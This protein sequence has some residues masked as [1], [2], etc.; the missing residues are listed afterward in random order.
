M[1]RAAAAMTARLVHRRTG[2][3]SY[4]H[5]AYGPCSRQ[6]WGAAR[7]LFAS[8][9][10]DAI[11]G[12]FASL[13]NAKRA[14]H[15]LRPTIPAQRISLLAPGDSRAEVH[16]VPTTEDMPPVGRE[17]AAALGGALG[18]GMASVL[19]LPAVGAVTVLGVIGAALGGIS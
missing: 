11:A 16:A 10:M 18:L 6:R 13:S 15:L 5:Q 14:I 19:L 2:T 17:M 12:V 8:M 7:R 4:G 1:P 3:P 9:N